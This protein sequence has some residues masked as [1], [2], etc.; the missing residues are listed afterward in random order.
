MKKIMLLIAMLPILVFGF[1]SNKIKELNVFTQY[2]K[3]DKLLK[4]HA[5]DICYSYKLKHPKVVVYTLY[6]DKVNKFNYKRISYF[7]ED[8]ELPKQYR[9]KNSDYYKSGFDKGHNAPNAQFDYNVTIQKETFLLSNITPQYPK[10]NR[11]F[12]SRLEYL[13]RDLTVIYGKMEVVTGSCGEITKI[14][15]NVSVP[16]Y[17]F[18]VIKPYRKNYVAFLIPNTNNTHSNEQLSKYKVSLFELQLKCKDLFGRF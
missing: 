17:F 14:G 4:K 5:F 11:Y 13:I 8:K 9:S 2:V 16:K 12:W 1:V 15:N 18:K 3:C 10:L 6:G 7:K